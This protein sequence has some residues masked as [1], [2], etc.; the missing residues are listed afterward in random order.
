VESVSI[1]T[2]YLRKLEDMAAAELA[3]LEI[4]LQADLVSSGED[5]FVGA[6]SL[7]GLFDFLK[8]YRMGVS[9]LESN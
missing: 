2:I 6:V 9:T 8:S 7:L 4:I 5:L 3:R 1:E